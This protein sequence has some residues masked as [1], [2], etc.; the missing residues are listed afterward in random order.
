MYN[1][2][3]DKLSKEIAQQGPNFDEEVKI[4]NDAQTRFQQ[5]CSTMC[6]AFKSVSTKNVSLL[7]SKFDTHMTFDETRFNAVFNVT[8][9]DCILLGEDELILKE[10]IKFRQYPHVCE[11]NSKLAKQLKLHRLGCEVGDHVI[12]GIHFKTLLSHC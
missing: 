11:N 7:L 8:Y 6:D 12:P 10:A 2:F 9:K 4:V 5:F 1:H 3:S